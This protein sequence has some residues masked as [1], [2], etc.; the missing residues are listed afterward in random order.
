MST[1]EEVRREW[2]F[3]NE[4]ALSGHYKDLWLIFRVRI[5]LVKGTEQGRHIWLTF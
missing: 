2:G 5:K 3:T 1:A 4:N